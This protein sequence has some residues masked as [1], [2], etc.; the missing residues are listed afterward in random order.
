MLLSIIIPVYNAK[1]LI[2]NCLDSLLLQN[3]ELHNFEIILINDGSTDNSEA[4]IK[5]Y[6]KIHANM[7]LHS[8]KNL[9]NGAARNSGV[10]LAKGKY[11][12]FLDSDDYLAPNVLGHLVQILEDNSLDI[13]GFKSV[14]TQST[15]YT[16]LEDIGQKIRHQPIKIIDGLTFISQY[17]YRAEVWWYILRRDFYN[18]ANISF[19]DRKFV[20]DSYITPTLFSQAKRVVFL[21]I[22]IHRYVQS[23]NS[24]THQKAPAHIKRHMIDLAFS[25]S[26]LNALINNINHQGSIKRLKNRQQGYVFFFIMRFGRSNMSLSEFK[27]YLK[28]FKSLNAYPIKNFIGKDYNGLKYK[29]LV[30]LCNRPFILMIFLR[31]HKLLH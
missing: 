18:E 9:G 19:Y 26:K 2:S 25:V 22:R 4:I 29:M 12:Y 6:T 28:K 23:E 3:I 16:S 14:I 17:N 27:K 5:E 10:K 24:I 21:P 15:N 30:Y 8:Q 1:L 13:L 11:I 31:L 7:I 20:Q